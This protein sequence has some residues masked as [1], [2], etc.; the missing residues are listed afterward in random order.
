MH[1]FSRMQTQGKTK[2]NTSQV[3]PFLGT[4]KPYNC[5]LLPYLKRL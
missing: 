5:K 2:P 1:C 4:L 3:H